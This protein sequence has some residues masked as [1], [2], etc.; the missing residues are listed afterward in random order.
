MSAEA[1]EAVWRSS[2]LAGAARFVLLAVAD[3]HNAQ[4]GYAWPSRQ[5][6]AEMVNCA[7]R[8][9][10]RALREAIDAGELEVIERPG[11]LSF[12]VI[13]LP[14]VTAAT[15]VYDAAGELAA[16]TLELPLPL[17]GGDTSSPPVPTRGD[18]TAPPGVT[19]RA[20]GG[21]TSCRTGDTSSP[22]P[23]N[24]Q[25][26][27]ESG[28]DTSP[29]VTPRHPSAELGHVDLAALAARLV[30]SRPDEIPAMIDGLGAYG[31]DRLAAGL[32]AMADRSAGRPLFTWP[33]EL[34]TALVAELG[35]SSRPAGAG[36]PSPLAEPCPHCESR[37]GQLYD[38]ATNTAGPCPVCRPTARRRLETVR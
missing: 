22:E 17:P 5:R 7:P 4:K 12:Y 11:H 19:P 30:R 16:M 3:H 2:T 26:P 20:E 34:R 24:P 29:P 28:G 32:T 23:K 14:G 6:L 8:S 27:E 18:E 13:R 9:V 1:R 37:T 10:P 35:P 31:P 21:D 38:P 33:S 15:P 36:R 25:E